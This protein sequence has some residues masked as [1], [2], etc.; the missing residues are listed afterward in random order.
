MASNSFDQ[1]L[2]DLLGEEMYPEYFTNC[3]RGHIPQTDEQ[4]RIP[5]HVHEPL[6]LE[7]EAGCNT[8]LAQTD[9]QPGVSTHTFELLEGG[10]ACIMNLAQSNEQLGMSA[11]FEPPESGVG[12]NTNL[13]QINTYII[14]CVHACY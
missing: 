2:H 4:P 6:E 13:A 8:N 1:V 7:G 12:C 3:V 14:G 10:T 5:V 11:H 9:K